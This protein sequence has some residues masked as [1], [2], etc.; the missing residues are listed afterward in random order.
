[1][2]SVVTV[3]S[4]AASSRWFRVIQHQAHFV[5][6]G[7]SDAARRIFLCGVKNKAGVPGFWSLGLCLAFLGSTQRRQSFSSTVPPLCRLAVLQDGSPND[8]SRLQR[9]DT[10]WTTFDIVSQLT[11]LMNL[12]D[13]RALSRFYK[14]YLVIALL[15]QESSSC[16]CCLIPH[17][18]SAQNT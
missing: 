14:R 5:R 3:E 11:D 15:A 9:Q 10:Q 6:A 8:V 4:A 12:L 17:K 13:K 1:V 16:S 18:G 2:A 7:A